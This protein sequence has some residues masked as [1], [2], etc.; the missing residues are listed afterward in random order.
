MRR[1]SSPIITRDGPP[2]MEA[3]PTG[4]GRERSSPNCCD[5]CR[6][7]A[8]HLFAPL[9]TA[10]VAVFSLGRPPR[11]LGCRRPAELGKTCT[12]T[13]S[14]SRHD[15]A[16]RAR[17][18]RGNVACSCLSRVVR[19]GCGALRAWGLAV[20]QRT[21]HSTNFLHGI[22]EHLMRPG[23]QQVC[24]GHFDVMAWRGPFAQKL[25]CHVLG[26][27]CEPVSFSPELVLR[28][29]K[30]HRAPLFRRSVVQE[31]PPHAAAQRHDELPAR[32]AV[33]TLLQ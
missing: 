7:Q 33:A 5:Q 13:S 8:R 12:L 15:F 16:G 28:S 11:A 1:P 6:G 32:G 26:S 10:H 19:R 29:L 2:R 25:A 21:C 23:A 30:V 17:I 3:R 20:Q 27:A 18:T 22:F 9:K 24:A 14:R 31:R 4:S